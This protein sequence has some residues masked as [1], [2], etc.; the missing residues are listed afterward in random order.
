MGQWD[1][2]YPD[3]DDR[4][5]RIR[6]GGDGSNG[7]GDFIFGTDRSSGG[8]QC[9]SRIALQLLTPHRYGG[10]VYN[11]GR[12]FGDCARIAYA[13]ANVLTKPFALSLSKGIHGSTSSP[14]TDI[15]YR[16]ADQTLA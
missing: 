12:F 2:V 10:G 15:F 16:R 7:E 9:Q 14:R 3:P 8:G 11:I 1:K 6:D 13:V 5:C 4:I